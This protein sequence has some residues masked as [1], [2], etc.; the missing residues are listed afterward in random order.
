MNAPLPRPAKYVI[1][2]TPPPLPEGLARRMAECETTMLGHILYWG[3]LD[4]GIQASRGFAPRIAGRAL[5]VMC[6]GPDSTILHHAIG[7]AAPGDILVIDRLGDD[8]YACLGDGVAEAAR[9]AGIIGAVI[10]GPC[11]DAVEMQAMGFPVWCRG[12]APVTTRLLDLG[13]RLHMPVSVG[14]VAVLAGD[15]VLADADGVFALAPDEAVRLTEIALARGRIAAE[16]RANRPPGLALGQATGATAMVE[17]D[18]ASDL[19]PD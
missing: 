12:T 9:A 16:R 1:G 4:R 3:C 19:A 2:P 8:K 6:P 11:T 14:G 10:D 13:G 7:Q 18:L 15:A 5:T 17:R